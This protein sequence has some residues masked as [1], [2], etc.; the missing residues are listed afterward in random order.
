MTITDKQFGMME[1]YRGRKPAE[2]VDI[3]QQLELF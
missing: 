2:P 1:I 3:P